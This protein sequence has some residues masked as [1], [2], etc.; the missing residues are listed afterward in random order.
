MDYHNVLGFVSAEDTDNILTVKYETKGKQFI[1]E[2]FR[3]EELRPCPF[4]GGVAYLK[5]INVYNCPGAR[6]E[7]RYC[8]ATSGIRLTG[9]LF[10]DTRVFSWTDALADVIGRWN[11]RLHTRAEVTA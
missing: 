1:T 9:P 4:C 11:K 5:P 3:H 2:H 7:C 8:H 10:M 6:V